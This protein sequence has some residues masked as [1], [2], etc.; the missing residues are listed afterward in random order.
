MP[1]Q[2]A[3]SIHGFA[4]IKYEARNIAL[5]ANFLLQKF[6]FDAIIRI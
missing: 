6:G 4:V 1:Q 5:W 2:V 3:D